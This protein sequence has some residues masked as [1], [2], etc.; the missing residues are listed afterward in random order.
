MLAAHKLFQIDAAPLPHLFQLLRVR[1]SNLCHCI[2]RDHRQNILKRGAY[3]TH[4]PGNLQNVIVVNTR[5]IDRI[6]FNNHASLDSLFDACPLTLQKAPYSVLSPLARY[7]LIN[8]YS[9]IRRMGIDCY[10]QRLNT[11]LRQPACL[12]R[13]EQ[14]ICT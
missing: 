10:S 6:D 4:F 13:K 8:M 2:A 3:R 14:T 12:L 5:N 11:K 1:R 7:M 9:H